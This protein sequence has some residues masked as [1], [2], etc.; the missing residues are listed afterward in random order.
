MCCFNGWKGQ[1]FLRMQWLK[2]TY[3]PFNPYQKTKLTDSKG[4]SIP[5]HAQLRW[6]PKQES[7]PF[8]FLP[9]L[10]PPSYILHPSTYSATRGK[11]DARSLLPSPTSQNSTTLCMCAHMHTCTPP[12]PRP[13][14]SLSA[15]PNCRPALPKGFPSPPLSAR[16]RTCIF[17]LHPSTWRSTSCSIPSQRLGLTQTHL[18]AW[19]CSWARRPILDT[20][21]RNWEGRHG[22]LYCCAICKWN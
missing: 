18:Q 7:I 1:W 9:A 19:C 20:A 14:L 22:T 21:T 13:D 3:R 17:P 4:T 16:T 15:Q 8:C 5:G 10:L 6:P 11:R 12:P 2:H